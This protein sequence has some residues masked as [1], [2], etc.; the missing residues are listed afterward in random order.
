[1][2]PASQRRQGGQSDLS[3]VGHVCCRFFCG[4]WGS[5]AKLLSEE[6]GKEK[7]DLILTS[8]TIYNL[9]NQPKLVSIFKKFL[10]SGGE[11]TS[12]LLDISYTCPGAGS[13]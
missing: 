5:L 10:K 4:D 13:R 2:C 8:E 1:M 12:H 9:E 7:F 3:N 11:V 6:L